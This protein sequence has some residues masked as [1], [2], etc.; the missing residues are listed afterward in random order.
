MPTGGVMD[1]WSDYRRQELSEEQMARAVEVAHRAGRRV[2]AHAESTTGIKAAVR[3]GVDSVEHD[4]VLDEEGAALME[5]TGTWL[6]PTLHTFQQ[7]VE[8]GGSL[9]LEPVRR[10]TSRS[11]HATSGLVRVSGGLPS[12]NTERPDYWRARH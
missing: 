1:P 10:P 5:A 6:V 7:G 3:A 2:M 4:T 8:L 11:L 12:G 9:G